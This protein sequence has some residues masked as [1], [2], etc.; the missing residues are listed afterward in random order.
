MTLKFEAESLILIDASFISGQAGWNFF[1]WNVWASQKIESTPKK[2]EPLQLPR[3]SKQSFGDK[4]I[5]DL[6]ETVCLP[7]YT[8]GSQRSGNQL[9]PNDVPFSDQLNDATVSEMHF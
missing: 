7:R 4:E 5:I 9:V 6:K 3:Q 2:A 1:P 8:C